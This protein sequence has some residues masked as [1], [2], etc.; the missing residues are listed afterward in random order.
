L[1]RESIRAAIRQADVIVVI[2]DKPLAEQAAHAKLRATGGMCAEVS[3]LQTSRDADRVAD[4][5]AV[6]G[7]TPQSR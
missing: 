5:P 6:A 2:R 4:S 3:K 7:N 1:R